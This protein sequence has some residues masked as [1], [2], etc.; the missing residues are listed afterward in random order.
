[1]KLSAI[2]ARGFDTNGGVVGRRRARLGW[3]KISMK[4]SAVEAHTCGDHRDVLCR[5]LTRIVSQKF[6]IV[7]RR[8]APPSAPYLQ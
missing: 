7:G 3:R 8:R 2:A 5:A 6:A 1:M 4:L